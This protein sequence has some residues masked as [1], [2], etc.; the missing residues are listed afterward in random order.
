M[1]ADDE[2]V[3]QSSVAKRPCDIRA[4]NRAMAEAIT[5]RQPF[6]D[7]FVGA[8][9]LPECAG[10][11]DRGFMWQ[12]A[13]SGA[14]ALVYREEDGPASSLYRC[15]IHDQDCLRKH[16]GLRDE[17]EARWRSAMLVLAVVLSVL[18]VMVLLFVPLLLRH[19]GNDPS[20]IAARQSRQSRRGESISE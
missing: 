12:P 11:P 2:T 9:Q 20:S 6:G 14:L 18:L 15:R 19:L 16:L 8:T 10:C 17:D 7:R 3:K 5:R 13:P 1:A 4:C